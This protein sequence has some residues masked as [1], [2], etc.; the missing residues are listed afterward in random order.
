MEEILLYLSIK[1]DGDFQKI[2]KALQEKEPVDQEKAN[3]V[4]KELFEKG[5]KYTTII[6]EDYPNEL[7]LINC[8]P[9]VI[10]YKGNLDLLNEKS[11][12]PLI[13]IVGTR[14]SDFYG[15]RAIQNIS[16]LLVKS[17]YDIVTGNDIGIEKT[18]YCSV[19]D[20]KGKLIL[21]LNR[22]VDHIANGE[23]YELIEN[24][25]NFD[26]CLVL[27]EYPNRTSDND[28]TTDNSKRIAV[29]LSDKVLVA[30]SDITSKCLLSVKFA[31]E[32]GKEV[33]AVP[34]SY[35][36]SYQGNNILISHGVK[37]LTTVK[38]LED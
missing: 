9:F 36:N 38:D 7:K 35:G 25:N 8:P 30:Q 22:G 2:L 28:N 6:S 37:I 1:Y 18:T 33:Y 10:Y 24:T 29:G 17:N 12:K 23:L 3:E 32:T 27:S 14:N 16:R 4:E 21:V 15:E 34:T 19:C 20:K 5:Y 31:Y 13:N 11:K 26:N